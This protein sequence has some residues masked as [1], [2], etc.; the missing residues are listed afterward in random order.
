MK[1]I[2]KKLLSELYSDDA[3]LDCLDYINDECYNIDEYSLEDVIELLNYI[4]DNIIG[5][6]Y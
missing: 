6:E 4:K 3:L 1:K 5:E 2:V